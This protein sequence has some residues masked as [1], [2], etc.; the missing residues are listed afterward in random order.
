MLVHCKTYAKR[1]PHWYRVSDRGGEGFN[2]LAF[3]QADARERFLALKGWKRMRRGYTVRSLVAPSRPRL[4]PVQVAT[5]KRAKRTICK[6]VKPV[7]PVATTQPVLAQLVQWS[8]VEPHAV[9]L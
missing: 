5:K 2:V 1:S 9:T 3:T 6:Q 4:V 8:W 7:T